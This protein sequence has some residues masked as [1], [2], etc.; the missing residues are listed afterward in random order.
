MVTVTPMDLSFG[1]VITDVKL[2]S[3]S[4]EEWKIVE[5]AFQLMWPD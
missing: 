4:D 1:A 5:D 3:M 2:G